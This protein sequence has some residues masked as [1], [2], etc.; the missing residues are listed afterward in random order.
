MTMNTMGLCLMMTKV[1]SGTVLVSVNMV[2]HDFSASRTAFA[3]CFIVMW[4]D[5]SAHWK[6]VLIGD[7]CI[8]FMA[9]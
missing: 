1:S 5:I 3:V 8:L 7:I 2:A 6:V 9:S 4:I